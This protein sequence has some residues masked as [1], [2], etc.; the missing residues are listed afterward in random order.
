MCIIDSSNVDLVIEAA[1]EDFKIKSSLFSSLDQI[2]DPHCILATNTSS[3]SINKIADVTKRAH[4]VIGMHF[5]NPV[6]IMKLI[7]IIK[8]NR[9]SSETLDKII[10]GNCSFGNRRRQTVFIDCNLNFASF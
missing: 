5:M 4:N 6:P 8:T 3:I 9:T 2:T 7:E 1:T 10:I